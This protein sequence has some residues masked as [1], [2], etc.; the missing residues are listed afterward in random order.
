[1]SNKQQAK[2][3]DKQGNNWLYS[4]IVK[5]HFFNP[6][7]ILKKQEEGN[8][9]SDGEGR[10]GSPACGDEM[11]FMIKVDPNTNK[12]TDCRWQTFGCASAIASTSILSEM[13]LENGGMNIEEAKK[14]TPQDI[15][16][17]LG[18]LPPRKIHC[19]VLGD[20]A[21]RKAIEDYN[22]SQPT[23]HRSQ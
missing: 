4:E 12:I 5:D 8:F 21:L 17:R 22:N 7:N 14:I 23:V 9:K 18:G 19:S 10:V 20:Q 6:R 11:L 13:I 15:L 1:M 16:K 3:I 2:I